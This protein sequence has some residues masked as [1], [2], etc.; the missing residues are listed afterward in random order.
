MATAGSEFQAIVKFGARVSNRTKEH[1]TFSQLERQ[2]ISQDANGRA[3]A[4]KHRL[5]A[6]EEPAHFPISVCRRHAQSPVEH[7]A[8]KVARADDQEPLPRRTFP[9]ERF[10]HREF[11]ERQQLEQ[12]RARRKR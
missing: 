2:R 1:I 10:S 7:F 11:N 12:S 9:G 3:K 5:A 4:I 8:A 6:V